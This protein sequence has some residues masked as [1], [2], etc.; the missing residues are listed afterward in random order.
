MGER[1]GVRRERVEGKE[2]EEEEEEEACEVPLR[3]IV[4]ATPIIS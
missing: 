3:V 4:R 2:E 1:D